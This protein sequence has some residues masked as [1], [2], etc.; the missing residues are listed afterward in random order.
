MLNS[1]FV[2]LCRV[3]WHEIKQPFHVEAY[4]NLLAANMKA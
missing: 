1:Y 3:E 2:T 4:K